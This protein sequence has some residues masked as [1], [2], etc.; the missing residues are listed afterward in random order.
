MERLQRL[1]E[2]Q[3]R[4]PR[5]R[6]WESRRATRSYTHYG[7]QEEDQDWRV[8]NFE[9]RHHQHPPPKPYFPFIKLPSFNG[10]NDPNVYLGW[11]DKVERIFNVYEV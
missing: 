11:E 7:S 9:E 3:E 4:Q 1:E 8:H 6:R 2:A 10:E 5:E